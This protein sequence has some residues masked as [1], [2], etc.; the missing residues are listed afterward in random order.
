MDIEVK[1]AKPRRYIDGTKQLIS[2][3]GHNNQMTR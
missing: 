1:G 2:A 3:F